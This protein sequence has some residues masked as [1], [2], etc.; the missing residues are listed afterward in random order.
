MAIFVWCFRTQRTQPVPLPVTL[1]NLCLTAIG[2]LTVG[3]LYVQFLP[4]AYRAD[5]QRSVGCGAGSMPNL[6]FPI[7]I[8]AAVACVSAVGMILLSRFQVKYYHEF[9]QLMAVPDPAVSRNRRLKDKTFARE[10]SEVQLLQNTVGDVSPN[11]SFSTNLRPSVLSSKRT[12]LNEETF[13]P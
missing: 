13:M 3:M 6:L 11:G 4:C 10:V 5:A 9:L 2:A 12:L 1:G 7:G 8:G